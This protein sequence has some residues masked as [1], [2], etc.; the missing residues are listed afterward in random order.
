TRPSALLFVSTVTSLAIVAAGISPVGAIEPVLDT[1]D[2]QSLTDIYFS[3][4][5]NAGDLNNDGHVDIVH[6]PYWFEGPDFNNKHEIFKAEPQNRDRYANHFFSWVY[7]FDG[8]GWND[9]FAVGFPG[10][11]AYVYQN[12]GPDGQDKPWPKHE[13]FD[14]VSNESPHFTNLVG[15]ERPELVCTRGGL[16][17]YTEIDWDNPFAPW[18]FHVI[19]GEI[20]PKNFGHGLGVGDV[21]GDGRNDVLLKDGWLEQPASLESDV[22]WNFHPVEFARKGGAEMYAYDV[23]GDGDNDVITSLEAH[24]YGLAW[25]EQVPSGHGIE[26]VKHLIMGRRPEE[27]RYGLVFTEPHSVNLADIDGDGL[28][29]IVTGK[30]Y[31]SHHRQSPMWDTGAVV[32][33]FRLVRGAD[34]VD[35][36]PYLATADSGIGRQIVVHDINGDKLPD[37]VVGGMKG[38]SVLVHRREQVSPQEFE[39]AQPKP[40][41]GDTSQAERGPQSPVDAK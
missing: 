36:V 37:I 28:M 24:E 22:R 11:P 20:A 6:G 3:E 23:D 18:K 2:R 14:S 5:A 41:E 19:S 16:F 4:G 1:F 13:V 40:Y 39:K 32:Y 33:W 35:W 27:N 38:C 17:G 34:G 15:D 31:W 26:F 10:T 29:D 8:D 9:T 7:D 21:N 30:T 12:P 25:F